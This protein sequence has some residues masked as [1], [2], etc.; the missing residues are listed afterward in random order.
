MTAV[1]FGISTAA[2]GILLPVLR[3]WHM[4]QQVRTDGPETHLKKQGTPTMGGLGF[5]TAMLLATAAFIL[6]RFDRKTAGEMFSLLFLTLGF[7]AVGFGDDFLKK[8]KKQSE[9]MKVWQKLLFQFIVA[10]LFSTY[11]YFC[12]GDVTNIMIPFTDRS[13]NIGWG[14]IPFAMFVIIGTD[15]GVNFTDGLDGLCSGV[16]VV[17]CAFFALLGAACG[18]GGTSVYCGITAGALMGFLV[19]NCHPAKMF[20]G[21]TGSLSLGAMVAG[22]ALITKQPFLLLIVGF[23]YVAEVLSDII[24][25]SYFKIT[26]GKRFFK[27]APIHHHFEKCGWS[28]TKVVTVFTIVTILMGI[29]G[30]FAVCPALK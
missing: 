27:M 25:I 17:V 2:C 10:G 13:I 28:E 20:M 18:N 7:G 30:Y 5:L 9:G 1:T 26:R 8:I 12:M 3:K 6:I 14:Y 24:Q 23:V 22:T 4:G 16:T 15:N 29:L 21:D 19:Y 11:L